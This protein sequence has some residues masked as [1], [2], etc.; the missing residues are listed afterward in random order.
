VNPRITI[1]GCGSSGGVPRVG[2]GWGACDPLEPKN[3]RRR[4]SILVEQD[5]KGGTTSVLVDTGPDLREQL[6]AAN[7]QR[8][9]AAL[10]S[11]E[12]ADHTHGLDDIRP[13]VLHM[14]RL[15]PVYMDE[16]TARQ[17]HHKFGYCFTTPEGSSYP[18]IAR[19][20]RIVPGHPMAIEGPGG[21]LPVDA[22]VVDHGEIEAL[23]FRFGGVAYTPD[24]KDIPLAARPYLEGLDVWIIDALRITPHPSHFSL[25]DALNWIERMKPKRAVLTNLHTDLDYARLR[26]ELPPHIE[27]AFDGMVIE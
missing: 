22:F 7:V 10:I 16:V 25:S 14:R 15:L 27:P 5:G 12:H 24:V 17:L 9:D 6:L 21:D 13:I 18:P 3:R 4:C 23:G 20:Y 26:A 11:H 19:E 1:L 8:L 2:S